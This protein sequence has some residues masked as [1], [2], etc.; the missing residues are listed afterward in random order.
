MKILVTGATG[1][2]GGYVVRH[3]EAAGHDI[4]AFGRTPKSW[5]KGRFVQGDVTEF[6][7]V[8]AAVKNHDAV[9]HLAAV[10]GPGR[11]A[12]EHLVT[13]NL[14]GLINVLESAI[15]ANVP[16]VVFASSGAALGFTFQKHPLTPLYF[17]VDEQYECHPQEPYGLS[18]LLGE[19]TCQSYTE[20]YGIQTVSLRLNNTWYT[21]REGA[22][23]AVQS[24]WAKGMT[25]EQ[26]W[27]VRYRRTLEDTSDNWPSPGPV[28]PRKNLWAVTD[29]RDMGQL[30]HLAVMNESIRSEVFN[31]NGDDTCATVPSRDLVTRWY[32]T[33]PV[34]GSLAGYASLVSHEK[35][36]RLLE[37]QP[38]FS[39]RD[40]DFADW[41]HQ[42]VVREREA[43]ASSSS[44]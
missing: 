3:L 4:T 38:R 25:V 7:S 18:K 8:L 15:R 2:V 41:Y 22:S 33:V 30:F 31:I 36:T 27:T 6:D 32:P 20:T 19:T 29:A 9:I 37:F 13:I 44:A 24:G 12:P 16:K 11:A 23:H 10:P 5:F 39:W 40:S 26:L 17:P 43:R 34:R 42:Q 21:D 14:T 35:A 28:N 1:T